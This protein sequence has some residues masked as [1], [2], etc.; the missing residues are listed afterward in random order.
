MIHEQRCS[1]RGWALTV[2]KSFSKN[3]QSLI[4][5]LNGILASVQYDNDFKNCYILEK[6]KFLKYL[7]NKSK[8]KNYYSNMVSAGILSDAKSAA[9]RSLTHNRVNI[10]NFPTRL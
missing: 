1:L 3:I 4:F 8:Q 2:Q 10:I 7:C 9:L 6:T 5:F